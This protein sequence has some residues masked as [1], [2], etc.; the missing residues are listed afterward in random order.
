MAPMEPEV[1]VRRG[2]QVQRLTGPRARRQR[3]VRSPRDHDHEAT[4][5]ARRLNA[6]EPKVVLVA[7]LDRHILSAL[8]RCGPA[9]RGDTADAT[10]RDEGGAAVDDV[11]DY[12]SHPAQ[13]GAE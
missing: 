4:E 6:A 1:Q 3:T 9:P 5:A 8:E 11:E 2:A 13:R 10:R 12:A 7:P